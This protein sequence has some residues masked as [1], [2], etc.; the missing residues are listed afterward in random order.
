MP[1]SY[2]SNSDGIRTIKF[3]LKY[4]RVLI[5]S[6]VLAI[7]AAVV[8]TM[9]MKPLYESQG[10]IFPT[11][12]NSPDKI[13]DEPQFGYEVD[14]DWLMQVLKSDIVRDSLNN[15]F[16]LV[17]YFEIDTSKRKW[18]DEFKKKYDKTISFERTKYMSI[19]VIVQTR[20]PKLSANIVN[21][22]IDNIDAIREKIFKANTY[23]TLI[24][25]ED[26]F[27]KKNIYIG[28]LVDSIYNLR[29]QN[30]SVS[31]SLL[32]NQ[33]KVKQKEVNRWR[34][35]LSKMRSSYKF[36]NLETQIENLN[37][38]LSLA[39]TNYSLEQG[40]YEVYINSYS[41]SDTL[42]IN[43]KARIEGVKKSIDELNMEIDTIDSAKKRYGELTEKIQSGLD[44][45]R[46]L[47][48]QYDNTVNAFEPFI[49]SVKLERLLNDYTHQQV[50]LNDIRYQYENSLQ[51]YN[52]PIPSVYIINRAEASYEKVSP[53]WWKIGLIII[54]STMVF[55]IGTLLLS[56]KYHSIRHLLNESAD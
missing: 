17:E 40:K 21:F 48:E 16:N 12:T 30:T 5:Y 56:E 11:P 26:S 46:K 37:S 27:F 25:F 3:L 7:I 13:L 51:K 8:V 44:Q 1:A 23:K 18:L 45:L 53:I 24:H 4:K 20:D 6:V 39:K 50:L 29:E 36:Y 19:R 41:K 22:V 28:E 38:N 43:T 34:E 49:N 42:V 35:E 9:L 31:L 52:N 54:F 14:A 32:Y 33:I 2:S 10:I 15:T 55:V 47:N